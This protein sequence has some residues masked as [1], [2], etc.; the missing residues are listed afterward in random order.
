LTD[1]LLELE[2]FKNSLE[3]QFKNNLA[4]IQ[5]NIDEGTTAVEQ[6]LTGRMQ[7][8]DEQQDRLI[9]K[10]ACVETKLGLE[11]PRIAICEQNL[12]KIGKSTDEIESKFKIINHSLDDM[13]QMF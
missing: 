3:S 4:T 10:V 6:R 13:R 11:I 7:F 1:K 12:D 2:I 9:S 8:C 5:A